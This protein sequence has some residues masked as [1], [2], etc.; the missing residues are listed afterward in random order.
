M[1]DRKKLTQQKQ[2]QKELMTSSPPPPPATKAWPTPTEMRP[3]LTPRS[4]LVMPVPIF[5]RMVPLTIP[6]RQMA[7]TQWFSNWLW[8]MLQ[9][10]LAIEILRV[11]NSPTCGRGMG[12]LLLC[13]ADLHFVW[14]CSYQLTHPWMQRMRKCNDTLPDMDGKWKNILEY[15]VYTPV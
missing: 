11:T 15:A 12:C 4:P 7:P 14:G 6:G 3:V 2:V 5:T 13:F 10:G 8:V 1:K 9:F